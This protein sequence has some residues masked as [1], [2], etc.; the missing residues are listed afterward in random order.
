MKGLRGAIA[1]MLLTL[2]AAALV[3]C[4]TGRAAD[5]PAAAASD[6]HAKNVIVMISDG[7]GYNQIA[8]AE[9][10]KN[11]R[12]GGFVFE[13]FPVKLAASTYPEG[14]SYDGEKAWKDFDYVK[15]GTTDSAAAATALATGRKTYNG[16]IGMAG[17]KDNPVRVKNILE[18]A[19]ELGKSTGVVTSVAFSHATPAGF[20]A[21]NRS[22][23]NYHEIADEMILVSATDVIMGCGNP[24]YDESGQR[25][26][27]PSYEYVSEATW[28]A[29]SAGTA[30]GDADNDGVNDPWRLIQA[31][32]EFQALASEKAPK[33]VIGIVENGE[34]LQEARAGDA[35][36]AAYAVARTEPEPTL[37][38]MARGALSVLGSN[39]KGFALMIEG[40]AV[41]YASHEHRTG[42][43]IEEECEFA[44]AVQTVIEWVEKES[45]WND[46]LL[47]VTADHETGYPT[48]PDSGPGADGRPPVWNAIVGE[49]A[50]KMPLVTWNSGSHT[51]T[52]VPVFANG[53]AARAIESRATGSDPV[54]GRYIDNTDVAKTVFDVMQ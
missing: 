50:G 11:G 31:R 36:A 45:S 49:G 33:R 19:E 4:Q 6:A 16:A 24:D 54:R 1:G 13:G 22:R 18:R 44:D 52:L 47:I 42:R 30:G 32:G 51:R 2:M 38:E 7:C 9:L 17:P 43:M 35:N 25:I 34:T 20:V 46:T 5:A 41:D 10:Y 8:A 3:S 29:V 15:R 40:G 21:H 48:G 23:D 37:S 27:K 28:K 14:G 39:P 12:T 53:G 26:E